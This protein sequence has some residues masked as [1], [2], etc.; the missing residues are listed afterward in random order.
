MFADA[1]LDDSEGFIQASQEHQSQRILTQPQRSMLYKSQSVIKISTRPPNNYFELVLMNSGAEM[2]EGPCIVIS[3]D[4]VTFVNKMR[5][6][7]E[8]NPGSD[9]NKSRFKLGFKEALENDNLCSKLLSGCTIQIAEHDKNYPTQE[10]MFMNFL[11]IEFLQLDVMKVLLDKIKVVSKKKDVEMSILPLMI[12][13]FKY[14]TSLHGNL[15]YS[16]FLEIYES[17]TPKCQNQIIACAE[18]FLSI[19]KHDEF[20]Q[21]LVNN[22][23]RS[24]D[25]FKPSTVQMMMNLCL[26]SKVQTKLRKKVF[27]H[28]SG[29]ECP[30]NHLPLLVKFLLKSVNFLGD[31]TLKDLIGSVRDGIV[32]KGRKGEKEQI[33]K[34]QRDVYRTIKNSLISSKKFFDIWQKIIQTTISYDF[35]PMDFIV[36]LFM[37]D[38]REEKC[39]YLENVVRIF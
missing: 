37:M 27:E 17:A 38:I 25:L 34:A 28:I 10:S 6:I 4:H 15:L 11:L 1:D 20:I 13:Q 9:E 31:E 19:N 21:F 16:T 7:L 8:K 24:K 33:I 5:G 18:S 3:C 23:P 32:F 2:D 35:K 26:D 30:V 36:L 39:N 29:D 22:I 14:V 12:S